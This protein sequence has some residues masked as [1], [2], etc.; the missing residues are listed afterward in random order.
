MN[1]FE[2]A[3]DAIEARREHIC[4]T[5]SKVK[6]CPRNSEGICL[7]KVALWQAQR[8][9]VLAWNAPAQVTRTVAVDTT[10]YL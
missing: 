6:T 5:Y 9:A 3:K 7:I 10:G 2:I 8:K 4:D 1:S